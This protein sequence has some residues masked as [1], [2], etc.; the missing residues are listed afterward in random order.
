MGD[1]WGGG[2]PGCVHRAGA[3]KQC[4]AQQSAVGV[5]QVLVCPFYGHR[6]LL[7]AASWSYASAAAVQ[8]AS[9]PGVVVGPADRP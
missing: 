6:S 4:P 1:A 7:E 2:L 5:P 8:P 3:Q 9:G